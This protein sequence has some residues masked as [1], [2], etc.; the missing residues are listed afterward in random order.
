MI[1]HYGAQKNYSSY[2]GLGESSLQSRILFLFDALQYILWYMS[3][4]VS[5]PLP[6]RFTSQNVVVSVLL[7]V[8][9]EDV[10][11]CCLSVILF[12]LLKTTP[13]VTNLN[14]TKKKRFNK[15]L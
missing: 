11:K 2:P 3:S 9:C 13:K 12:G 15:M 7:C 1:V 8:A 10:N 4:S 14:L 6:F 5:W